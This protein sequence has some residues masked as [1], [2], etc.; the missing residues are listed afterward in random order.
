MNTQVRLP[1]WYSRTLSCGLF[2][3]VLQA[4]FCARGSLIPLPGFYSRFS[5]L[6]VRPFSSSRFYCEVARRTVYYFMRALPRKSRVCAVPFPGLD[7]LQVC[8][9][10]YI[11]VCFCIHACF[12]IRTTGFV[13]CISLDFL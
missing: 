5:Q 4:C 9:F 2:L 11:Q 3:L 13:Q 6:P 10:C 8:R 12:A 1:Y 7:S